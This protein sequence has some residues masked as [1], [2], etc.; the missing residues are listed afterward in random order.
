MTGGPARLEGRLTHVVYPHFNS[1]QAFFYSWALSVIEEI[2]HPV[3]MTC[4]DTNDAD[5]EDTRSIHECVCL[6]ISILA[7]IHDD[8]LPGDDAL[9]TCSWRAQHNHSQDME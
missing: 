7:R 8:N 9:T 6:S 2:L 1:A 4:Q 3:D 5:F